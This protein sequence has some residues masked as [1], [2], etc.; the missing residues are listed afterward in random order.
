MSPS[1]FHRVF[2]CVAGVIPEAYAGANRK[3]RVQH[4]LSQG[5]RSVSETIYESGFQSSGRFYAAANRML[6]MKPKEYQ[7]GGKDV[8]ISFAIGETSLGFILVASSQKGLCAIFLGDDPDVL[9]R[10]LQHRFPNAVLSGDDA[11]FDR[12][13]SQVI[14]SIED[15]AKG[16]DLPLDIRG[17]AFQQRVW[18]ALR[19]IPVGKTMSY[20]EI[21]R[22][23]GQPGGARAVA[24]ACASNVLAGAIPCHRVV[25]SDGA[26]SG[27]RWGADR[28]RAVLRREGAAAA[29]A[30][31]RE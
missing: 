12:I 9:A 27:Y 1:H 25:K 29:G 20:A 6:G 23:L 4:H 19:R 8:R 15:P 17:T 28:K 3:A 22:S 2:K 26:I 16:L 31:E 13:V 5:E 21:A 7:R 10:D 24:G 30:P 18:E 14:R 11:E